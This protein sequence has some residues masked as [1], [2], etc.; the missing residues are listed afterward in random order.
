MDRDIIAEDC[1]L[2]SRAQELA[3]DHRGV[4]G[5]EFGANDRGIARHNRRCEG[6]AVKAMARGHSS[7]V[8]AIVGNFVPKQAAGIYTNHQELSLN[9]RIIAC[10]CRIAGDFGRRARRTVGLKRA[11]EKRSRSA[12]QG[13]A[14]MRLI[15]TGR[16]KELAWEARSNLA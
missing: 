9:G 2:S 10:D 4:F 12:D 15:W 6:G 5:C 7:A 14:Q 1:I 3:C 16:A 13:E 11:D 8:N